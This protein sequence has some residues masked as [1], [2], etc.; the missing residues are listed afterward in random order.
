MTKT[1]AELRDST[2]PEVQ[3]AAAA[4]SAQIIAGMDRSVEDVLSDAV[5][6][7]VQKLIEKD[8][9]IAEL[10]KELK[11]YKNDCT[12][13]EPSISVFHRMIDEAGIE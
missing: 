4:Q 9:R 13:C 7:A 2:K 8:K 10:E 5:R 6:N 11:Y 12:G 1:L 3:V